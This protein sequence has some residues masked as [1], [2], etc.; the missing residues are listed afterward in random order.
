MTSNADNVSKNAEEFVNNTIKNLG[1]KLALSGEFL[2]SKMV[3]EIQSGIPPA[4]A[5]STIDAK[6]SSTP[7]ID[8]GQ[9]MGDITSK[10]TGI[11][12]VEVGVFG[13]AAERAA[14]HEF[15]TRTI[16]ERS[17]MR[18]ALDKNRNGIIQI[19]SEK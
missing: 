19:L 1:L 12:V 11:N 16:P 13:E 3:E 6:G 7:L 10:V 15:G 8:T 14:Y 5:Q 9:M 2:A 4:L 17:F 18:S